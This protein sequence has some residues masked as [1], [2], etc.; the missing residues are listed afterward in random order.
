MVPPFPLND[1]FKLWFCIIFI[2]DINSPMITDNI[3]WN[4]INADNRPLVHNKIRIWLRCRDGTITAI[5]EQILTRICFGSTQSY[6]YN[7]LHKMYSCHCLKLSLM[8][9]LTYVHSSAP[10]TIFLF[11]LHSLNNLQVFLATMHHSWLW[12][13]SSSAMHLTVIQN[14]HMCQ[15]VA[16]INAAI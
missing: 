11:Y 9:L 1:L 4:V 5:D 13:A 3:E 8:T 16:L 6:I 14:M 12:S 2:T 7:W 15:T 10:C